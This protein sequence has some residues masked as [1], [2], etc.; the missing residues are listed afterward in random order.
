MYLKKI[1]PDIKKFCILLLCVAIMTLTWGC[2]SM[3][4]KLFIKNIQKS[5]KKG[6]IINT[7]QGKTVPFDQMITDLDGV[8]II[9]AGENHA[10]PFHHEIQL[11]IIKEMYKRDP[12]IIVGMEMF[13]RTYQRVLNQWSAGKLN[14]DTFLKRVHW[15]ANWK[16]DFSLYKK[17]LDYIR[18]K[19][20]RLVG[21]NIPFHIPPK[22]SIG[23]IEN[24]SSSEKRHLPKKIDTSKADHRAFVKEV[25]KQHKIRGRDN[26]D[27]FYT[28]Q[29]VWEDIMA[30]S[31][32]QN[33]KNKKMVVLIGNGHIIKKFG[34][35]DRAHS[36]TGARF[37]TIY[38]A[39]AGSE[40]DR[41]CA[42]Y[43][44]VTPSRGRRYHR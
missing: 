3:P 16:Y 15:Y 10:D 38:P 22:I 44:W 20:I 39:P 19:G 32:A 12:G 18:E 30:E 4:E 13:D 8:R 27:Y 9:Y 28:A 41:S 40:A 11:R 23:G 17:I 26:F 36:R 37:R 14:R 42:D 43:I 21:L 5:Y 29:C 34:V 2:A 31:I 24:L 6:S 35:P 33:L 1:T 7:E 25:F